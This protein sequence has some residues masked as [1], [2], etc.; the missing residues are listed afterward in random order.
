MPIQVAPATRFRLLALILAHALLLP[1][2]APA[3]QTRPRRVQ[4]LPQ[5]EDAL[6]APAAQTPTPEP[7]ASETQLARLTPEP[8]V[9]IGLATNARS[10][11]ISTSTGAL[12]ASTAEPGTPTQPAPLAVARVRVEPRT[13]AP[14]LP[15]PTGDLFRVEI[16]A[17]VSEER[18]REV[19]RDAGELA[20]AVAEVT[21]DPQTAAWRVTIGAP[22]TRA[23]A[24]ELCARLEEAGIATFSIVNSSARPANSALSVQSAASEAQVSAAQT[25][26][27]PTQTR[28]PTAQPSNVRL[29]ARASLPTRGLVVFAAGASRLL[30]SHAP[31]TFASAD[32]MAAPV[33]FNEKPYRGRI[34]VFTNLNGSL[35][36]V[37]IVGLED[38]VRG[39]VPN[40]LSPGGYGSGPALEALKAQAVAARTYAVSNRGQFAAA[41]F[42]LLPTT[43][44]QVYGGLAT[45]HPLTDR[46]VADTRGLVATYRGQ[47]INALY[48]STC[49]GH[50]EDAEKIFGGSTVPYLRGRA[51]SLDARQ[52]ASLQSSSAAITTTREPVAVRDAER[53]R[54]PRD[55]ALLAVHGLRV[56]ARMT[57]D[58]LSDDLPVEEA[59]AIFDF[60]SRLARRATPAAVLSEEA[61]RPPGF[62]TALLLALDGESRAR[63]LLDEAT[64]DYLLAFRDAADIPAR[65]R[66]DVAMLIRDGHLTLHPDGSLRPRSQLTR[67]RAFHAVAGLL[68]ARGIVQLQSATARPSA[69][70]ALTV[71][72]AKGPERAYAV[73]ADA[74]L[75]RAFADALFGVRS[76]MV[77]GG[78]PVNFHTDARGAIDYLEARPAPNGAAAE[79]FS[80]YTN[81]TTTLTVSEVQQRLARHTGWTGTLLDLRVAARGVSGRALDLEVTGASGTA[82]VRDGRI[83][84]ALGLREQ[85]FVIDRR[86]DEAGRLAGFT[87]T[88]RGWG[89]GVGLCQ[90]GAYGLARAGLSYDR[91]L[92]HYYT[93]IELTRIY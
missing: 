16:A 31:V 45:E 29:A 40:E 11:T 59:H 5:A 77:V 69:A 64:V 84:T 12:F 83:R 33:R 24:E 53:A 7:T 30:D 90:V 54:G 2:L 62:S 19:A 13:F 75:F 68:E 70:G 80:P 44:S 22:S 35:T 37:N 93:G 78:E 89:H 50:T 18:A 1:T 63:V 28:P 55:V 21:R 47:P 26:R 48:T 91:I 66:A 32:E 34:E 67:A 57:D 74:Y 79:R 3:Q 52:Y 20:G 10:V 17:A 73:A 41:G 6:P 51:C 46:A 9:R 38:Y 43:R 4:S 60:V 14:P 36:V 87:F 42:D 56:P 82:H 58:W 85:L 39:V 23:E 61:T 71:R 65:N 76:L 86:Y 49:G 8:T 27:A 25:S 81:W 72:G 88:G 15:Q 92:K